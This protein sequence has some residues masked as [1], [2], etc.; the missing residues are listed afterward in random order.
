MVSLLTFYPSKQQPLEGVTNN[1]AVTFTPKIGVFIKNL[2]SVKPNHSCCMILIF[3]QENCFIVKDLSVM[4]SGRTYKVEWWQP[5]KTL[6]DVDVAVVTVSIAT[7]WRS[8]KFMWFT[9]LQYYFISIAA[10]AIITMA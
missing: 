7:L 10:V 9:K 8:Q 5:Q 6:L 2:K 3:S 4:F 1:E